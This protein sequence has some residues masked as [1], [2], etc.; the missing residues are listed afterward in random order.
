MP[1]DDAV[2]RAGVAR[3]RA[4][5]L[6]SLTTF[7]GLT[8]LILEKATQ[9]QFLIPMAVSLGFGILFATVITLILVPINYLVLEDLRRPFRRAPA[10]PC[11]DAQSEPTSCALVIGRGQVSLWS[12]PARGPGQDRGTGQAAGQH[13]Q[14]VGEGR[15]GA[16]GGVHAQQRPQRGGA[17]FPRPGA[18]DGNGKGHGGQHQRDGQQRRGGWQRSTQCRSTGG[19][20]RQVAGHHRQRQRELD[21]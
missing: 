7:A 21:Q 6:T 16:G 8:P 9:A 20:N 15:G 19:E 5:M 3:F 10:A 14:A 18:A 1:L 4:V 17:Q 11:C 2:R 12:C 13:H